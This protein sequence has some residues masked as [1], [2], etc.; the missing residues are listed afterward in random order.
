MLLYANGCSMTFGD[1]LGP[2]GSPICNDRAWPQYLGNLMGIPVVNDAAPGASNDRIVRRTTAYIAQFL[3]HH[4]ADELRVVIGWTFPIRREFH[5]AIED[6]WYNFVPS[7]SKSAGP[8]TPL[9]C[10]TFCSQEESIGRHF[11]QMLSVQG[12]LKE[13]R[14]PYAFFTAI[15]EREPRPEVYQ[16]LID[17]SRY[18]RPDINFYVWAVQNHYAFGPHGHPLETAHRDWAQALYQ[19]LWS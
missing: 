1:E 9:Y 16:R 10:P 2:V 15:W 19:A 3:A 13:H 4:P 11:A 8:L 6:H 17:Y 5:D 14:I 18:Y 7:D 12:M